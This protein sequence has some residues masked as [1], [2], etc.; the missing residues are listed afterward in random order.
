MSK[1]ALPQLCKG[2]C[3]SCCI[4]HLFIV[5][6]RPQKLLPRGEVKPPLPGVGRE[7]EVQGILRWPEPLWVAFPPSLWF[8]ASG[9]PFHCSGARDF[10]PPLWP[11][12]SWDP[13][14]QILG[15]WKLYPSGPQ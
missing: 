10:L 5:R 9:P 4:L 12:P 8:W 11:T 13:G 2:G 7:S 3:V 6:A 1:T 14:L 15:L